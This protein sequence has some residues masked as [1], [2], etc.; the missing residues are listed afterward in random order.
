MMPRDAG[1]DAGHSITRVLVVLFL[2]SFVNFLDRHMLGVLLPAIKVDLRL[3]DL[4]LGF[5]ASTAFG[6]FYAVMGIP[7]GRLA[8][9]RSPRRV[10]AGAMAF[11]SAMTALCGAATSFG[12]LVVARVLVGV[13]EAGATPAAN[14][15]IAGLVPPERRARAL[16]V[17][18]LG[19]PAGLFVGLMGGGVLSELLGWR[20]TL[21]TF[22]LP[23]LMLAAVVLIALPEPASRAAEP[24]KP[25]KVVLWAIASAPGFRHVC[26]GSAF[27][28]LAW[29]GMLT[30]LPSYF[31]RGYGFSTAEAGTKLALLMAGS[32]TIGL[33]AGGFGAD[34]LGRRDSRWPLW[35]CAG[36]SLLP[37]PLYFLAFDLTASADQA[38]LILFPAFAISLL[39][40]APALSSVHAMTPADARGVAVAAYL[41]VVNVIG[42]FGALLIGLLSDRLAGNGVPAPLADAMLW[43]AAPFSAW[44][45]LHFWFA[46][47]REGV[48]PGRTGIGRVDLERGLGPG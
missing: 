24:P 34:L 30:W 7:F 11:W 4:Q 40:G 2:V 43:V 44:S 27:F 8:D 25:M 45:A 5:M 42:G 48:R 29:Q 22:G 12:T 38:L 14:A 20:L 3:T 15:L 10:M 33:L 37:I 1:R 16:S 18:A 28:T 17:F 23:G 13:G 41:V 35:I 19:L 21:L 26:L 32:Q 46:S 9:R 31:T 36:A 47:R 6:L 39:Q